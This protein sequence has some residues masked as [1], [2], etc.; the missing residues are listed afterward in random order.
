MQWAL[1]GMI[2]V[3]GVFNGLQTGMNSQLTKT[4]G[5]PLLAA[6]VVYVVGLVALLAA[7]SWSGVKLGDYSKLGAAPWWSY[8]GGLGGALFIYAM[9]STTQKIGAGVF[10][11]TTVTAAIVSTVAIDHFGVLGV[12]THPAGLGRLAGVA[13]ML[14]GVALVAKF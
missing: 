1:F 10:T 11:A 14:G 4:L 6:P 2:V 9:L 5:N 8:L 13:L 3:A 7:A 12:D